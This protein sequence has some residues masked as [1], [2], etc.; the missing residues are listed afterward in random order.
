[1][2][3]NIIDIK[4]SDCPLIYKKKKRSDGLEKPE[5]KATLRKK[6]RQMNAAR[7]GRSGFSSRRKKRIVVSLN[8]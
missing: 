5:R 3:I 7:L 4:E 1:V 8:E 6:T 2:G